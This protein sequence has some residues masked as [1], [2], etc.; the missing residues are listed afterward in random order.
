MLYIPPKSE[1]IFT[2]GVNGLVDNGEINFKSFEKIHKEK[3]FSTIKE[4]VA[5]E[6]KFNIKLIGIITKENQT[7][8]TLHNDKLFDE[9]VI[10]EELQKLTNVILDKLISNLFGD[11]Q[12]YSK[13]I[14]KLDERVRFGGINSDWFVTKGK[15]EELFDNDNDSDSNLT[16]EEKNKLLYI[17]DFEALIDDLLTQFVFSGKRVLNAGVNLCKSL[18]SVENKP[19]DFQ[20]G[21]EYRWHNF[22]NYTI[23]ALFTD[24]I[25]GVRSI[26][27]ICSKIFYELISLPESFEKVVKFKCNG[28]KYS[29][30]DKILE[31]FEL[32]NSIFSKS[33][34]YNTLSLIRNELV[35]NCPIEP[36]PFVYYGNST[37][38]VNEKDLNYA[39]VF[40][41]DYVNEN[42]TYW[43]NRKRFFGHHKGIDDFVLEHYI[44]ISLDLIDTFKEYN[45]I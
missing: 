6:K 3:T 37:T 38:E 29:E 19:F 9:K 23:H 21:K 15:F 45:E 31:N 24:S 40:I 14:S 16:V 8:R 33:D 26:L 13:A 32:K 22:E 28:I 34:K 39:K 2:K 27:D 1:L 41:W 43:K 11:K 30:S 10:L 20:K 5:F 7:V 25:I 35:H 42:L 17:T 18:N 36:I 44:N 12:L 4:L